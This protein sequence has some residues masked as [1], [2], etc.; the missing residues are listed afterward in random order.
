MHLSDIYF[1]NISESLTYHHISHWKYIHQEVPL[2]NNMTSV[3]RKHTQRKENHR[4][5]VINRGIAYCFKFKSMTNRKQYTLSMSHWV[6]PV[7]YHNVEYQDFQQQNSLFYLFE[8]SEYKQMF[9]LQCYWFLLIKFNNFTIC[10]LTYTDITCQ[11]S[12]TQL[13]L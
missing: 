5:A 9:K 11:K 2:N 8:M 12:W 3:K 4:W 13:N 10:S 1:C 6:W 7:H